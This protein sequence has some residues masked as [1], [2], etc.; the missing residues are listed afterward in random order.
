MKKVIIICAMLFLSA[1]VL[2][3]EVINNQSLI[4]M[5]KAGLSDDIIRTK[6]ATEESRFDTSTNAILELKNNGFS[7]ET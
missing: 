4:E 5:K 7:D 6:I 2:A 1:R 3:Q